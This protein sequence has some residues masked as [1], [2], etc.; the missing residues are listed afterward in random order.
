MTGRLKDVTF[1][2][3]GNP[4]LTFQ[5]HK[6]VL[7]LVDRWREK[8]LDVDV[9]IHREKRSLDANAYAWVLIDKIAAA[10]RVPKIDVYRQSVREIGGNC[11]Y[12][13]ALPNAVESLKKGWQQHGLGWLADEVGRGPDGW[14]TVQLTYG[15]STYNTAQMSRLIDMLVY[16]AKEQGIETLPPEK[17]ERL[18]GQ[19]H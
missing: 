3:R 18:I 16:A 17:I 13:R 2:A 19:W 10:V 7:S 8:D 5:V 9:K 4:L 12:V 14:V 11:D 1:D 6:D 15:S